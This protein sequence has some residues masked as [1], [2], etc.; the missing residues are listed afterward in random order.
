M[1][2]LFG[3]LFCFAGVCTNAQNT[4]KVGWNTYKAGFVTYEYTYS[5]S[6]TDSIRLRVEDST[7][8]VTTADSSVSQA[9][10]QPFREKTV[11]R[12]ATFR[13]SKKQIV[14]TEDYK[15]DLLKDIIEYRYDDKGRVVFWQRDNRNSGVVTKKI[16]D[17]GTDKKTGE[18]V[19]SE[20]SYIN[21]RI[22]FYTKSYHDKSNKKYKEVRLN[23]NNKDVIHIETYSYGPAGQI[24]ERTVYFPEFKVTKKFKEVDGDI[25][26][27]CYSIFPL[28]TLEQPSQHNRLHYC[29]KI[30]QKN[31]KLLN[32]LECPVF[33]YKFSNRRNCDIFIRTTKV[34]SGRQ[35]VFRYS[36]RVI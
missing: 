31:S 8:I 4:F 22:E 6:I 24:Q 26:A 36:D 23:D 1:R 3:I 10:H 17:Y 7:I 35:L 32:D 12:T 18:Q 16:Y 21:G 2:V 9:T 28:G 13:N 14:K 27:K 11:Y 15:D 25:M 19:V 5:L 30:V 29:K 20:N 34:N 33:E